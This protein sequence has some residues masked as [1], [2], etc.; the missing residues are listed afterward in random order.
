MNLLLQQDNIFLQILWLSPKA[1]IFPLVVLILIE[2]YHNAANLVAFCVQLNRKWEQIVHSKLTVSVIKGSY[3]VNPV[4][5]VI[6]INQGWLVH[7]C[8]LGHYLAHTDVVFN[9][10]IVYIFSIKLC[11]CLDE[12]VLMVEVCDVCWWAQLQLEV[13]MVSLWALLK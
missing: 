5:S 4:T 10:S 6:T 13:W 7:V 11:Y 8:I 12:A 1:D 9:Y 3:G 2:L